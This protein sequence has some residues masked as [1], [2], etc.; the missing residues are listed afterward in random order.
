M[1]CWK[2][3]I[4]NR[5]KI[6]AKMKYEPMP[7]RSLRHTAKF[8]RAGKKLRP[9]KNVPKKEIVSQQM[10]PNWNTLLY[11]EFSWRTLIFRI[12]ARQ[13]YNQK[14]KEK[15][16]EI[17]N[18]DE[19]LM[20]REMSVPG[21]ERAVQRACGLLIDDVTVSN[22]LFYYYWKICKETISFFG[23]TFFKCLN[24]LRSQQ[25]ANL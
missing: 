3:K 20:F 1:N 17:L 16:K 19:S 4:I 11:E 14:N 23:T 15:R 7:S 13:R 18:I 21:L 25:R 6:L 5:S 8:V 10:F 12:S 22:R 9:L 2:E 24:F